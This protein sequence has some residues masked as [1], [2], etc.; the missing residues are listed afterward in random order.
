M[1]DTRQRYTTRN[2]NAVDSNYNI[3]LQ[4]QQD[5]RNYVA[6]VYQD[7]G[8][9][10]PLQARNKVVK[11]TLAD[12]THYTSSWNVQYDFQRFVKNT[13]EI[14]AFMQAVEDW[15]HYPEW[16]QA[17]ENDTHTEIIARNVVRKLMTDRHRTSE[18]VVQN[19]IKA[20]AVDSVVI[21]CHVDAMVQGAD[22]HIN[23]EEAIRW[24][25]GVWEEP[26]GHPPNVLEF[27]MLPEYCKHHVLLKDKYAP[28]AV[29]EYHMTSSSDTVFRTVHKIILDNITMGYAVPIHCA[30]NRFTRHTPSYVFVELFQ[31][32][33]WMLEA[34][35]FV[36]HLPL[37]EAIQAIDK[38]NLRNYVEKVYDQDDQGRIPVTLPD[39]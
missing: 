30:H 16:Q 11:R 3:M 24:F 31:I 29:L 17:Q 36:I 28:N 7:N 23:L 12:I 27:V 34:V 38:N 13:P 15:E 35:G 1:M 10:M 20:P 14:M 9:F 39:M 32:H 25:G 26:E 22:I 4:N 19:K 18:S 6:K 5:K 37:Q 8:P 21:A 33:H 2:N